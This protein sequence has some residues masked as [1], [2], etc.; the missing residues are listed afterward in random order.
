MY[1]CRRE[2]HVTVEAVAGGS[3]LKVAGM[4]GGGVSICISQTLMSMSVRT[5]EHNTI[6]HINLLTAN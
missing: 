4:E 2:E 5:A 6:L 1:T 3:A